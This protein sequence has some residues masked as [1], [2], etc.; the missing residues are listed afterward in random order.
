MNVEVLDAIVFCS[1]TGSEIRAFCVKLDCF[2]LEEIE[3]SESLFII[4]N[5][6][7]SLGEY[8]NSISAHWIISDFPNLKRL[9]A[10][11]L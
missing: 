6:I 7:N 9:G 10:L 5:I 4:R 3:E 11:E 2:N 1:D 8:F